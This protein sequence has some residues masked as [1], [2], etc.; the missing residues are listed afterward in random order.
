MN[1]GG[2]PVITWVN[3]PCWFNRPSPTQQARRVQQQLR[4]AVGSPVVVCAAPIGPPPDSPGRQFSLAQ[5]CCRLM[6]ALGLTDTSSTTDTLGL[7]AVVFDPDR[8]DDLHRLLETTETIVD[9][10]Q[11]RGTD[12]LNTLDIY[13]INQG[14]HARTARAM[15]LHV[16][17]LI[18]RI[19]RINE[20]I[21]TDWQQTDLALRLQFAVRFRQLAH[22]L[23]AERPE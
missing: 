21:G 18:K 3:Q 10:D 6:R 14:N 7:Y 20:L 5:R 13:F 4:R 22:T 1:W 9:Y 19:E 17:T 16:N 8:N 23:G 2:W 15:D 12:L 11:K